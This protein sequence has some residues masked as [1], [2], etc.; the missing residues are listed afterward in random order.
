MKIT[1]K[2]LQISALALVAVTLSACSTGARLESNNLRFNISNATNNSLYVCHGFS[3]F[4]RDKVQFNAD[5]MAHIRSFFKDVDSSQTER[6]AVI[7]ALS[8]FEVHAG[9]IVGTSKDIGGLNF[10][11]GEKG[12]QD[13]I[14]ESVT[15]GNFLALLQNNNLLQHHNVGDVVSRGFLLNGRYPHASATLNE[16]NSGEAWVFDS[17]AYDNGR[18]AIVQPVLQWM[19]AP[20]LSRPKFD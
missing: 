14:D 6:A 12:Q 9:E 1:V 17:W 8:W 15:T 5:E 4:F 13:C 7:D 2:K 18:P 11:S 20:P 16:K 19:I 3:C 10:F